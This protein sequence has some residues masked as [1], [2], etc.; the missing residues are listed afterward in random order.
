MSKGYLYCGAAYHRMLFVSLDEAWA[1]QATSWKAPELLL[2]LPQPQKLIVLADE[3]S[4]L[5]RAI[6]EQS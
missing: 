4:L 3:F 2:A 6:P 5:F 1:Q